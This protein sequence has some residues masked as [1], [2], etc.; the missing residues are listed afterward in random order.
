M[1]IELGGPLVSKDDLLF[2]IVI[3]TTAAVVLHVAGL[4]A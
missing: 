2:G 4:F 1:G 3:M